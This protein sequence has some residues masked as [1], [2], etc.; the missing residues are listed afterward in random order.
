MSETTVVKI[1][2]R[3][4]TIFTALGAAVGLGAAFAVGPLLG[5][6]LRRF[7]DAPG[8]LRVVA[9]LPFAWAIPVLTIGGAIGGFLIASS[10]TEASGTIDVNEA[11][12]TVHSKNLDRYIPKATTGRVFAEKKELVILD[13][14]TRE[15][16][17]GP[18]E[19]EMLPGL[20]AA[21]AQWDYPALE[22]SDP[23][24]DQFST[25]VEGDGRLDERTEGL[26]R[27]RRRALADEQPG[28]AE[29][30]LEKLR[31]SGLMVRDRDGRQQ[32]RSA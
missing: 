14:D 9:E 11:G 20:R 4:T 26:L 32:Y 16:F 19:D 7:G 29:D 27:A 25:W 22:S 1:P 10:W 21:L 31:H 23:F 8:P 5:W 2:T 28:T 12:V 18:V 15:L 13:G 3:Y 6:L 17:R 30:A 24:G